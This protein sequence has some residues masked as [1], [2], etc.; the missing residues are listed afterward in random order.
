MKLVLVGLPGCGRTTL[1]KALAGDPDLD[2]AKPLTVKVPDPR[3]DRLAELAEVRRKVATSMVFVDV[4]SP[5]FEPK[6]M[7]RMQDASAIVLVLDNYA[8]GNLERDFLSAEGELCLSDL[9]TV[10]NRSNRLIKEGRKGCR[11]LELL[12][13]LRDHLE[14]GLP[15]RT[16]DL[17][18]SELSMLR[19]YSFLSQKPILVVIN[20]ADRPVADEG[21]LI[22][23]ADR[24][25]ASTTAVNAAFELEL[26]ELPEEEHQAFLGSMGYQGSSLSRLIRQ[27]YV[28]L[29]LV[30]FFTMNPEEVRAWPLPRNA[31]ALEAA[32]KVHSDMAR[33]FVR[34]EVVGFERFADCPDMPE[35]RSRGELR[36]EG[37]DYVIR[38]GDIIQVRFSV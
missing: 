1:L 24:H 13:R 12:D 31:T 19:G 14:K 27:A 7:T 21:A 16:M 36:V 26:S 23:V 29:D 10:E 2:P 5:A 32:G 8:R 35:L 38:D 6:H 37:K 33:G 30:T 25:Q 4:P 20:R 28:S 22:E 9:S 17:T 18:P 15:L 34:A 3:L 11:E